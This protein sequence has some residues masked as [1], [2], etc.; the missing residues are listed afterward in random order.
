[1][2]YKTK[3]NKEKMT[4]I[5]IQL[6]QVQLRQSW[7]YFK[8]FLDLFHFH[9]PLQRLHTY[10]LSSFPT[11]TPS[12]LHVPPLPSLAPPSHP[13]LP[14]LPFPTLP[15]PN[16]YPPPPQLHAPTPYLAPIP[17]PHPLSSP[18][19]PTYPSLPFPPSQSSPA[20][21]MF[22]PSHTQWAPC[23]AGP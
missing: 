10:L 14:S 18:P 1:M 6:V 15:F 5:D 8:P 22:Q 23:L 11:P 21:L 13:H 17:F 20:S 4:W 9:Y 3:E 7:L 16:P 19:P 12:H 2:G